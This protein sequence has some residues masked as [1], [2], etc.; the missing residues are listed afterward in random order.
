[1]RALLVRTDTGVLFT[2]LAHT[3][4]KPRD[5]SL[6]ASMYSARTSQIEV[7]WRP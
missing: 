7:H 5:V 6:P 3:D 4:P 2:P 1:V